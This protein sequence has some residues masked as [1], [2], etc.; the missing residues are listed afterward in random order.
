MTRNTKNYYCKCDLEINSCDVNCCCD[1]D[2][3]DS[4]LRAFDCSLMAHT[5][6]PEYLTGYGIP[7]CSISSSWFCVENVD[8]SRLDATQWTFDN[9]EK[10]KYKKWPETFSAAQ[11]NSKQVETYRYNDDLLILNEATEVMDRLRFPIGIYGPECHFM[12]N[13]RFLHNQ[14]S[15]CNEHDIY[16]EFFTNLSNWRVLSDPRFSTHI[17]VEHCAEYGS[18]FC[19]PFQIKVCNPIDNRIFDVEN[20]KSGNDSSVSLEL[21]GISGFK[22]QF[23]H[24]FTNIKSATI[25]LVNRSKIEDPSTTLFEVEFLPEAPNNTFVYQSSGNVGYE[26]SKPILVSE[27]SKV[28]ISDGF[29]ADLINFF[30]PVNKTTHHLSLPFVDHKE[31]CSESSESINFIE[32]SVTQCN[33]EL[34][35]TLPESNGNFTKL[36]RKFQSKIF[37]VVYQSQNESDLETFSNIFISRYGNP[38]NNTKHWFRLETPVPIDYGKI[39]GESTDDS[40]IC[41]NMILEMQIS[42][43]YARLNDEVSRA[44]RQSLLQRITITFGN[45]LDL[46]FNLKEEIAVPLTIKVIF[47]DLTTTSGGQVGLNCNSWS[48]LLGL[49]IVFI[50]FLCV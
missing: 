47:I 17:M 29:Q 11:D 41:R 18:E 14:R 16:D 21:K 31:K 34:K 1:M 6:E 39:I 26:A 9:A 3:P 10:F 28:N 40:F 44:K 25:L 46:Q 50:K 22:F 12:E 20:C 36:C 35:E 42:V 4:A 2:C 23:V 30:N 15:K 8:L 48:M 13:I 38:K 43:F 24:N 37:A 49:M 19:I 27:F 5:K 7:P 45:Q 33:L 32:N